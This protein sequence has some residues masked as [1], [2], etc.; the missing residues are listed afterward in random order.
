MRAARDPGRSGLGEDGAGPGGGPGGGR[1][2]AGRAGGREPQPRRGRDSLYATCSDLFKVASDFRDASVSSAL[3][4][5]PD[6]GGRIKTALREFF[7][8]RHAPTLLVI[9]SLDE[10][11]GSDKFLGR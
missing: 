11:Y 8:G 2:S 6:M 4:S 1:E 10:A 9:D 5:L 7:M 3:N